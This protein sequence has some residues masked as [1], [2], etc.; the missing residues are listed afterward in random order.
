M[1]SK[2][3]AFPVLLLSILAV[4][5]PAF[6]Q[7]APEYVQKGGWPIEIGAGGVSYDVDFGHGRM[8]GGAAWLDYYPRFLPKILNGLGAEIEA[9]DISLD[10]SQS[11]ENMRQDTGEGG[12][13]YSWRHFNNFHPYVKYLIGHGSVDFIGYGPYYKHDTR[14]LTAPGIGLELRV[15]RSWWMRA[16]YE[17]QNWPNLVGKSLNPQGFTV[18]FAYDFGHSVRRNRY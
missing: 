13:I 11:Q 18:G 4:T 6:S 15:F 1:R 10:E 14:T 7:V 2:V 16:D 8:Y 3:L 5:I 17:Y 9:R 12:P